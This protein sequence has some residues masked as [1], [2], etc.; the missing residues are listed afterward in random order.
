[1]GS[2]CRR[3]KRAFSRVLLISLEGR[4]AF[5]DT[6]PALRQCPLQRLSR[7]RGLALLR[8]LARVLSVS[9]RSPIAS[10]E[11]SG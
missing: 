9:T 8:A 11:Q 6:V 10:W 3:G 4:A 7:C 5:A 2:W 1:M